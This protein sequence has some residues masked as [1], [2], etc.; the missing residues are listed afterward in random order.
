MLVDDRRNG[1]K[2]ARVV[3]IGFFVDVEPRVFQR[4]LPFVTFP[5]STRL[6]L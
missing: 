3:S 2:Q 1:D 4:A 5:W 6:L